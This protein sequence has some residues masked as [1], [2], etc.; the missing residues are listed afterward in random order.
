MVIQQTSDQSLQNRIA[1]AAVNLTAEVEAL[2][3][4]TF[5][6]SVWNPGRTTEKWFFV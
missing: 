6:M 4:N 1:L 2:A 3:G 5:A